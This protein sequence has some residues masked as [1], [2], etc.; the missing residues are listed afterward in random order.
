M[1]VLL[2]FLF[3]L[4]FEDMVELFLGEEG[5]GEF[6]ILKVGVDGEKEGE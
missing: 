6:G 3:D 4:H 1:A 5:T 2:I